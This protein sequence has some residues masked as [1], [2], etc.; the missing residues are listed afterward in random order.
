MA[1]STIAEGLANLPTTANDIDDR[2]GEIDAI[3]ASGATSVT[4]DG[5]TSTY[6]L[7]QLRKERMEL[8]TRK[9]SGTTTGQRR[10]PYI[11]RPNLG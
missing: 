4:V 7:E 11:M 9:E 2:L 8:L 5:T 1:D 3:L 6:N 10:R